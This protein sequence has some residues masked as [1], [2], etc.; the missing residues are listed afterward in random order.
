MVSSLI[1]TSDLKAY[2]PGIGTYDDIQRYVNVKLNNSFYSEDAIAASEVLSNNPQTTVSMYYQL[3]SPKLY[4]MGAVEITEIG[5]PAN[6][7]S[8]CV[9]NPL[10][11]QLIISCMPEYE[12]SIPGRM[13]HGRE[14]SY[15]ASDGSSQLYYDLPSF[16]PS[17]NSRMIS[18]ELNVFDY[19]TANVAIGQIVFERTRMGNIVSTSFVVAIPQSFVYFGGTGTAGEWLL[20]VGHIII[21]VIASGVILGILGRRLFRRIWKIPTWLETLS[22]SIAVL[23]ITSFGLQFQ[24]IVSTPLAGV[25]LGIARSVQLSDVAERFKTVN[26]MNSVILILLFVLLVSEAVTITTMKN[27]ALVAS[28]SVTVMVMIA[29]LINIRFADIYSF[30]QSFMLLTRIGI[31]FISGSEFKF[32]WT[33][34]FSMASLL[35]LHAML[36]YWFTG[37]IIG[38]LMGPALDRLKKPE[39]CEI[40]HNGGEDIVTAV[41]Q[42]AGRALSEIT[43]TKEKVEAELESARA[44]LM[45]ARLKLSQIRSMVTT[46]G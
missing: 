41:D 6:F 42:F 16:V 25:N 12:V 20:V 23:C 33:N 10:T 30:T 24:E 21:A 40:K 26:E 27:W 43:A 9:S 11:D 36:L 28:V 13:I 39:A 3:D 2:V 34:G 17:I 45:S 46:G 37:M 32:L 18:I 29:L 31:R 8:Q 15:S 44:E 7:E 1:G 38:V 5:I 22:L 14:S 4:L 19:S 35:V